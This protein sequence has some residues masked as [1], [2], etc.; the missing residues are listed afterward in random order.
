LAVSFFDTNSNSE[1]DSG[2]QEMKIGI[3]VDV[4]AYLDQSTLHRKSA[5]PKRS[6]ATV[7]AW[8][9]E[10]SNQPMQKQKTPQWKNLVETALKSS[11]SIFFKKNYYIFLCIKRNSLVLTDSNFSTQAPE[12]NDPNRRN[13]FAVFVSITE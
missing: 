12:A 8:N 13:G 4:S 9:D 11:V 5:F 7:T 1:F 3:P 6:S 10:R 2:D